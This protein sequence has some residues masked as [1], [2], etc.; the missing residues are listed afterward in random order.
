MRGS[1]PIRESTSHPQNLRAILTKSL[2]ENEEVH[3]HFED[4]AGQ[5][6]KNFEENIYKNIKQFNKEMSEN[7]YNNIKDG[8]FGMFDDSLR[9]S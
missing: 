1:S 2:S 3:E 5:W 8:I 9:R 4:D 7:I 6:W